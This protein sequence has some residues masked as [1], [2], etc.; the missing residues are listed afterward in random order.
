MRI[1]P[2]QDNIPDLLSFNYEA[3]DKGVNNFDYIKQSVKHIIEGTTPG[4]KEPSCEGVRYVLGLYVQTLVK[5][6]AEPHGF[7]HTKQYYAWAE[8]K[9]WY[10]VGGLLWLGV[11]HAEGKT[12][13]DF[14]RSDSFVVK[15][16]AEFYNSFFEECF[17]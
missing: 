10:F 7:Y 13:W 1:Q 4:P 5:Y 16:F 17:G 2:H 8:S 11:H 14:V 6:M 9:P 15:C 12:P 3:Y